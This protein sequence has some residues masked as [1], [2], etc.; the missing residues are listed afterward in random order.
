MRI[1]GSLIFESLATSCNLL[2]QDQLDELIEAARQRLIAECPE[3]VVSCVVNILEAN[4]ASSASRRRRLLSLDLL[5][6]EFELV[7]EAICSSS[8]CADAEAIANDIY[9]QVT[10]ELKAAI[11][12]GSLVDDLRAVSGDLDTLLGTASASGDFSDVV[13]PI[14]ALLSVW[15]PDWGHQKHTCRNDGK[16]PLYMKTTGSY[17][18][19]SLADCCQR[20]FSWQMSSCMGSESGEEIPTGYYPAWAEMDPK[21]VNASKSMPGYMRVS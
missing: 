14:L 15:Y 10:G 9:S 20:F 21:C 5:V 6:I 12:G 7:I 17:Y 3:G 19:Q 11:D 1:N 4:C 8:S 2:N 16:Q 18:E 13:V